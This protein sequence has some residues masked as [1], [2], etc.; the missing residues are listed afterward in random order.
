MFEESVEVTI[1]ITQEVIDSG[2]PRKSGNCPIAIAIMKAV[3][4]IL[5]DKLIFVQ[6]FATDLSF[7]FYVSGGEKLHFGRPATQKTHDFIIDFD[8]DRPVQPFTET[9][10]FTKK[11]TP[12]C[13]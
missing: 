8:R 1:D 4:K 9:I 11:E 12:E 10:T 6:A 2:C 7:S 3:G 13:F 5:P